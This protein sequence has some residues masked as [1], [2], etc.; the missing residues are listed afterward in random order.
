VVAESGIDRAPQPPLLLAL[1][2]VLAAIAGV[3]TGGFGAWAYHDDFA[4]PVAHSFGLWIL[5]VASFS[6]RR[7]PVHAA[8]NSTVAL[9]AAVAAFEV[10]KG[11]VYGHEYPGMP[12][13]VNSSRLVLWLVL[14][15]VAGPVLGLV[16]HRA[17]TA[18]LAGELSTAAA[19]GLLIGDAYRRGSSFPDDGAALLLLVVL[20]VPALLCATYRDPRQ[21]LRTVAWTVPMTVCGVLLVS[22]PDVLEQVLVTGGFG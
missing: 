2:A 13:E 15:T 7:S 6:M 20:A 21:L 11:I 17:G 14:A 4:R 5:V 18:G 9:W 3:V 16:F 22:L 8:L 1:S 12:Y 19:V 10:G